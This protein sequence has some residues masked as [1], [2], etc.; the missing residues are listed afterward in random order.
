MTKF[1][2]AILIAALLI[3][4]L[5]QHQ[6]TAINCKDIGII[7]ARGSGEAQDTGASF[8]D[9]KSKLETKLKTTTLS[10]EFI[11][12]EYPAIAV[13]KD[14]S[15]L[16]GAFIS[17]GNSFA[18][19]DSVKAGSAALENQINSSCERT[20]FILAGYSQGAIVIMNSLENINPE[21]IIYAATFGD[22][23][24]FLPEGDG[25]EPAACKNQNIS[26]YRIYVPD[27]HAYSGIL[28]AKNPYQT[29]EFI[30]K[31][32]TWCNKNDIMCSSHFNIRDHVSYIEDNLN[33]DAA[34]L[35][36]SKITNYYGLKNT[37]SSPHDTVIL[38]DSTGSMNW[39]LERA[40]DE[41][42][43]LARETLN[44]GGRVALYEYRDL[45]DP[46]EP[47]KHCDFD[48]CTIEK[49]IIEIDKIHA[50]GGGDDKE[51]LLSASY[52]IMRTLNWRNGA[53]KSFVVLTDA[54]FLSPDR[55]GITKDQ[56]VKLS[57]SIDPVNFYI[58]TDT[59][60]ELTYRELAEVTDGKVFTNFDELSLVT[61][62][63]IE[64]TDSLPKVEIEETTCEKPTIK[65]NSITSETADS[66]KI[67]IT[68]STGKTLVVLNET[69]LGIT[70]ENEFTITDVDLMRVNTISLAPISDSERG[71]AIII[72]LYPTQNEQEL[73]LP[74]LKAPN[75]GFKSEIML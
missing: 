69:I 57:A 25:I 54:G 44:I 8:L 45:A 70:T 67:N 60:N 38:I 20:K 51:S 17:G 27:C 36:F 3:S 63:I 72:T 46:F 40:K 56:V 23:K 2:Y 62:Y 1:F 12:L 5:S 22:P 24:I 64:R 42:I 19:G 26:N 74:I 7:F 37:I 11:D 39:M 48:T 65:I 6:T 66:Y 15:V 33:E 10:Y 47:R 31:L 61:D 13:D 68:S 43:R 58:I 73:E 49:F 18:F 9:F 28:G 52:N 32:G 55:D 29:N 14:L 16:L 41:A 75:T 59:A 30:D 53:T 71:D 35:I 34:R 21:R 4:P 50:A